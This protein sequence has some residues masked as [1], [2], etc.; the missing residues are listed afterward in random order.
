MIDLS[1]KAIRFLIEALNH[2]EEHCDRRLE[3]K[4][5]PEDKLADLA[6]DRQYLLALRDDLQGQHDE[7][8]KGRESVQTKV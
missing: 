5:L 4:G 3:E 6:N 2:Y 8:F 1:P 7:L